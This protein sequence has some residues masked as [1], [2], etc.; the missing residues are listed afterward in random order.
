MMMEE[1]STVIEVDYEDAQA[2]MKI[3]QAEAGG[4]GV[5]G[6]ALVMQVVYNRMASDI[7][8]DTITEVIS[9]KKQFKTYETGAYQNAQLTVDC[10]LALAEFEKGT[11]KDQP[12]IGFEMTGL[13][14]LDEYFEYA[15]TL[16][17]HDFYTLR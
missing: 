1:V 16:K 7:F 14:D 10:H 13:R 17:G 3:A 15:F 11:Y 5:D 6:M 12:I 2:L 4:E 8:P 9:Q